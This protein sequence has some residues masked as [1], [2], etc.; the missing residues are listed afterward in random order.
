LAC[1]LGRFSAIRIHI[2]ERPVGQE[3]VVLLGFA[4][5]EPHGQGQEQGDQ[6][7]SRTVPDC[8]VLVNGQRCAL[9]GERTL[10]GPGPDAPVYGYAVP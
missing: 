10:T 4:D 7:Q 8:E 3:V 1:P 6:S 2:G 5:G 9:L